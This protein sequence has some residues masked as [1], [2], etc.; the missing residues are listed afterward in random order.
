MKKYLLVTLLLLWSSQVFSEDIDL[1]IKNTASNTQRP[2]VLV[3][4][5]NS[6]SMG[7]VNEKNSKA[8]DARR[9]IIDLINDNSSVDFALQVFNRN[10]ASYT[11]TNGGRII[12]GFNDLSIQDNRDALLDLLDTDTDN[13]N[14][15]YTILKAQNTPLCE[16]LYETY[17][18]LSGGEVLYGIQNGTESTPESIVLE[19]NYTSPFA[20]IKCNKEITIIYITDGAATKDNDADDYIK[21]LTGAKNSDK[22]I[23]NFLGVLGSW[24]AKRNWYTP[25]P[26]LISE[27]PEDDIVASVKIHTIGFGEITDQDDPDQEE[28]VIGLLKRAARDGE[29]KVE[30]AGYHALPAGGEYHD[31]STAD[32]LKGVLEAVV[33]EVLDSSSLTSAS[34]SASS[35]DRTLTLD[36]VYYGLFEPTTAARWQGN[37]KKYKVVDGVQVDANGKAAINSTGDIDEKS[38]SFWSVETDGNDVT[39]GGVA[40]MLRGTDTSSRTLLTDITSAKSLTEFSYAEIES[41]YTTAKDRTD[42]FD[43][44]LLED[45]DIKE[46]IDWAMGVDVDDVDEDSA[47]KVRADVFGDPLHSKP[48]AIHYANYGTRIVVGTNA[49][50][51]H[52][53]KDNNTSVV[54]SWAYLPKEFFKIIKPLRENTIAVNNKI[55]GIDGEITSYINDLNGNGSVDSGDTAWLFFGLRRGGNSYYALDITK[56]DEP[57]LMWHKGVDDLSD[58]GQTWSK[59]QVVRSAYNK[60]DTDKLV[61]VFGGGYDTNKDSSVPNQ[62][63]DTKGA[64][65][66]M[67]NA[68]TGALIFKEDTTTKNS[69]A[70]S[71]A[72][73]DSDSDGLTDRLYVGDTGGNV[74]R[75]DMP[76]D[77]KDERS[78]IKFASVGGVVDSEDIRFFNKPNI[79]RTYITETIDK[80]NYVIKQ[81]IPYDTILIGSGDRTSPTD[82]LTNDMFFMFKDKYINTKQLNTLVPAVTPITL[83]ELYDYTNDPFNGYPNLTTSQESE[84]VEASLKSGWFYRLTQ[85]GEK[86]TA[87]ALVL[88]N[89]VYFTSYSPAPDFDSVCTVTPGDAWLYAVDLSL[90]IKKYTYDEN[91]EPNNAWGTE[92]NNRNADDRIKYMGSQYLGKATLISTLVTENGV[93]IL[94][95]YIIVGDELI[96]TDFRF[97]TMRTSLTIEEN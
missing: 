43:I 77:D 42:I 86:S 23:G 97:L 46:H 76:G 84:L 81:K 9:I 83:N 48:V 95:T 33:E 12:A 93:T 50:V 65:V 10:R 15:N 6:G 20:G 89:V 13:T 78:I 71:V 94:K 14:D 54:E 66:Y 52:M 96:P 21:A 39:K 27:T 3:I 17:R 67:V 19:G 47:T 56:P 38:K 18:Y 34:V 57:K 91:K 90:G 63:N 49:G 41:Q 45:T 70:A 8:N 82:T 51:L 75:V 62:N 64:S 30:R 26:S 32:D 44:P 73:L 79:V 60:D 87:E 35:L 25:G 24:M 88:N 68:R 5:D 16:T 36:S 74:W 80:G 55:Y 40:E 59:P 53:F 22:Y 61:V 37:I 2:N 72:T 1:Y 85:S 4:L 92:L 29:S 7:D 28:D 11:N 31:A 69:I 58:L